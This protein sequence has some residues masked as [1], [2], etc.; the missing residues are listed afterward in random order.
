MLSEGLTAMPSA[1]KHEHPWSQERSTRKVER[2]LTKSAGGVDGAREPDAWHWYLIDHVR[3]LWLASSST[4]TGNPHSAREITLEQPS[5][6]TPRGYHCRCTAPLPPTP[7][8][9]VAPEQNVAAAPAARILITCLPSRP[10]LPRPQPSAD[11][12]ISRTC[13]AYCNHD[14]WP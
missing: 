8:L 1:M 2:E 13:A 7:E 12:A 6:H 4:R 11:Q 5:S 9:Y 10:H 3:S 14:G